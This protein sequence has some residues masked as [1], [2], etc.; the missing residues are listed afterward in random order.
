MNMKIKESIRTI[1]RLQKTRWHRASDGTWWLKGSGQT[2]RKGV[3]REMMHACMTICENE[4]I[5]G[6]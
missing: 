6:R 2:V 5:A 4:E 3:S 1:R